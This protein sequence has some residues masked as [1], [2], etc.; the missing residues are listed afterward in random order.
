MPPPIDFTRWRS[1]QTGSREVFL[2]SLPEA[3]GGP[4]AETKSRSRSL[5]APARLERGRQGDSTWERTPR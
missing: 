5:E 2:E 4:A 1:T 3:L